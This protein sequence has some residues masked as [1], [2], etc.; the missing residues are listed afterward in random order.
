MRQRQRLEYV[1]QN[2]EQEFCAQFC[3]LVEFL[4]RFSLARGIVL[5][6]HPRTVLL[7]QYRLYPYS[8]PHSR[9]LNISHLDSPQTAE[10]CVRDRRGSPIF[11]HEN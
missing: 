7:V 11:R 2:L 4:L 6:V 5:T 10:V 1:D 8:N 3:K 9:P